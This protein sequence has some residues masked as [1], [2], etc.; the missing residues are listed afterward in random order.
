MLDQVSLE[1]F[2]FLYK[3]LLNTT[4][5]LSGSLWDAQHY[6]LTPVSVSN[7]TNVFGL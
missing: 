5:S 3:S 1:N 6:P 7:Q 4:N 2:F